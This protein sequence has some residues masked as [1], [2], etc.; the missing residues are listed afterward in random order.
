M[1]KIINLTGITI[2]YRDRGEVKT[3]EPSGLRLVANRSFMNTGR[4][5]GDASIVYVDHDLP[6]EL[7]TLFGPKEG[8]LYIVDPIIAAAMVEH[9]VMRDDVLVSHGGSA[10]RDGSGQ[11]IASRRFLVANPRTLV[12]P[13]D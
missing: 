9:G 2:S 4:A 6:E 11:V 10:E 13:D 5:L 3:I 7:D 1:T 12:N 8:T